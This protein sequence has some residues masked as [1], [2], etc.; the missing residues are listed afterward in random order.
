MLDAIRLLVEQRP[1]YGYRRIMALLNRERTN[2]GLPRSNPKRIY[3]VMRAADLLLQPC[4]GGRID[5][6]HGGVVE[7]LRSD[8][9]GSEIHCS[10]HLMMPNALQHFTVDGRNL[11]GHN[12]PVELLTRIPTARLGPGEERAILQRIS[13]SARNAS[14]IDPVQN[15]CA[16]KA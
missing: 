5:R 7:T 14:C 15:H 13:D 6:A 1:T 16:G 8:T 9:D 10:I 12:A 11:R 4:S 3:R 2:A